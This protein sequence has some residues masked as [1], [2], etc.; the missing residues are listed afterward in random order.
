MTR[1]LFAII[2][3][4]CLSTSFNFE[5]EIINGNKEPIVEGLNP[6]E[7]AEDL[8]G[9]MVKEIEESE[10][11][12]KRKSKPHPK[13]L[14]NPHKHKEIIETHGPGFT[15]VEVREFTSNDD[16]FKG[17]IK[18]R[19]EKRN[20]FRNDFERMNDMGS[21]D[22]GLPFGMPFIF[23]K[24]TNNRKNLK[25]KIQNN[26]NNSLDMN[27]FRIFSDLDKAF[28]S[29]F[30]ID[31]QHA[32]HK[33]LPGNVEKK[34]N[35]DPE[36]KV[37]E[38]KD[39][40]SPQKEDTH[41]DEHKN[42]QDKL[43]NVLHPDDKNHA[44]TADKNETTAKK[45][46][47][48]PTSTTTS[49]NKPPETKKPV[50]PINKQANK[51]ANSEENK[52]TSQLK[53]QSTHSTSNSK[54]NTTSNTHTAYLSTNNLSKYCLFFIVLILLLLFVRQILF[55]ISDA[56]ANKNPNPKHSI[57]EIED[58]LRGMKEKNKLF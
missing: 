10:Q 23:V 22:M 43:I 28:D 19:E 57:N 17:E 48:N 36:V 1:L 33:H 21:K 39:V 35:K 52:H 54:P 18:S 20:E 25:G 37:T 38:V 3:A 58:E 49:T 2:V 16:N 51:S 56:E 55:K 15:T 50:D 8:I 29:F 53:P 9:G 32:G 11:N 13:K 4:I 7:I 44:A 26:N 24:N 46:S 30:K 14:K 6:F 42:T 40:H 12:T 27:P 47:A 5:I 45:H 31:N 34:V 41:I